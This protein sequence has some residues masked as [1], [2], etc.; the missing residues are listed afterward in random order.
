MFSK[1]IKIIRL[2]SKTNEICCYNIFVHWHSFSVS[3]GICFFF[4]INH[5]LLSRIIILFKCNKKEREKKWR[6]KH[7]AAGYIPG[8]LKN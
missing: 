6:Q 2:S 7:F 4:L 3:G 8:N 5:R 1:M